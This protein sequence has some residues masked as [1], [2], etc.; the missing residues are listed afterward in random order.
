MPRSMLVAKL[1]AICKG[2]PVVYVSQ[3]VRDEAFHVD[4]RC[5]FEAK[6]KVAQK[7]KLVFA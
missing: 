1:S 4:K 5:S 3:H 2:V 7:D 6:K